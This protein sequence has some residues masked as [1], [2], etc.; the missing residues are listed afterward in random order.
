MDKNKRYAW[1]CCYDICDKKRLS[2]VHKIVA[3]YGISLNYS[4][5][6]LYLTLI[7]FE[8]LRNRLEQVV[9]LA[10]D[11]RL[12]RCEPLEHIEGVDEWK[13]HGIFFVG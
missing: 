12:Y 10:D 6:Y 8:Q 5:F 1:L 3:K 13:N 2:Q 4:V 7:E 11:V 9:T